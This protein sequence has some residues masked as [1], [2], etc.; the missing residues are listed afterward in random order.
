MPMAEEVISSHD[1]RT[2]TVNAQSVELRADAGDFLMAS[3]KQNRRQS[4]PQSLLCDVRSGSGIL[5]D[6]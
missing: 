1:F 3:S 4:F 6:G 5:A 2:L